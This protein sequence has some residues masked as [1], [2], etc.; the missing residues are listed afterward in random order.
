MGLFKQLSISVYYPTFSHTR[1]NKYL[2]RYIRKTYH[3]P[4]DIFDQ[5]A[6]A[7]AQQ[8]VAAI[9]KTRTLNT[10]KLINALEGQTVQG[11]KGAYTIRKQDHVC[12]QPMYV[13]RL[14]MVHG[15]LT[16]ILLAT[17]SPHATAPAIQAHSW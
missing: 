16:P 1:A 2:V 13:T 8:I 7:A 15:N 11:P 14:E 12:L 5:D 17:K 10:A 4:A 6:F 3:R 9:H